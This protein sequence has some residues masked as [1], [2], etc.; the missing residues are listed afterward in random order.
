MDALSKLVEDREALSKAF[1]ERLAALKAR[2]AA[3]LKINDVDEFHAIVKDGKALVAEI[4]EQEAM[5]QIVMMGLKQ[6]GEA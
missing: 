6:R 2:L 3:A 4:E 5:L 1:G